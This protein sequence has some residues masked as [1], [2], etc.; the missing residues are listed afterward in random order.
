MVSPRGDKAFGGNARFGAWDEDGR[1]EN[2]GDSARQA[3]K[4]FDERK[5]LRVVEW[6]M[7]TRVALQGYPYSYCTKV[8]G[9]EYGNDGE[10]VVERGYS[11]F[12]KCFR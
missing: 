4:R 8:D 9:V 5:P 3:K 6:G 2:W 10:R 12:H 1:E 7:G 11:P